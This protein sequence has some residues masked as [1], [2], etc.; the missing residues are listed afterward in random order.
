MLYVDWTLVVVVVKY[1]ETAFVANLVV[2][3][4]IA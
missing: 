4:E 1:P 2:I 3:W